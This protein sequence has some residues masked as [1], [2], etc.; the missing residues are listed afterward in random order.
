MENLVNEKALLKQQ[1]PIKMMASIYQDVLACIPKCEGQITRDITSLLMK[2]G[3][4]PACLV[5]R[6]V[7]LAR[8]LSSIKIYANLP[9]RTPVTS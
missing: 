7:P 9:T 8:S 3:K 4:A 2:T 6:H 1:N 5:Y